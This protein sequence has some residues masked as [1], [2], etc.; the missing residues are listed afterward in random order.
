[1]RVLL[2]KDFTIELKSVDKVIN[3]NDVM[4][5]RL[6]VEVEENFLLPGERL[7]VV[8]SK[9]KDNP[10]DDITKEIQLGTDNK[11]YSVAIPQGV[12]MQEGTW[13]F[14]LSARKYYSEEKYFTRMATA[15]YEFTVEGGLWID[16]A[17]SEVVNNGTAQSLYE[18]AT[19]KLAIEQ[20]NAKDIVAL[21]EKN[22][23]QDAVHEAFKQETTEEIGATQGYI[24]RV[25]AQ[26][27]QDIE[28]IRVVANRAES[29]AYNAE[30]GLSVVSTQVN[31][32]NDRINSLKLYEIVSSLPASGDTNKLYLVPSSKQ[33]EDNVLE[34]WLWVNSS[35]EMVG[36]MKA[37]TVENLKNGAGVGAV[38]QLADGVEN[39]FDFTGKNPNAETIDE[40]LSGTQP[41]GAIGDFANAFG[42]KSSAQGKRS[43]TEGTTTIAKGKYSHAEGDNS[44]ALGDDSHAEGYQT[45]AGK[46]SDGAYIAQHAEGMRTQ[47]LGWAAHSEGS[48]TI[49]KGNNS[50]A[51]GSHT[52][53]GW[54]DQ[55]VIG[56]YNDNK[57]GNLFEVGNGTSEDNRSNA[58]E[59][60]DN[61]TAYAGGKRLLREGDASGGGTKLYKHTTIVAISPDTQNYQDITLS[62]QSTVPY[63]S[64]DIIN[65]MIE[66]NEIYRF[67]GASFEDKYG[68]THVVQFACVFSNILCFWCKCTNDMEDAPFFIEYV[69][70]DEVEEL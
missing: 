53:A 16:D 10:T 49:A 34:E 48:D 44:V 63:A 14:I 54:N 21:Q 20:E 50:H 36:T 60:K 52:I 6:E 37:S 30:T 59:V 56:R 5:S 24:A 33:E 23:A 4:V 3:V 26:A 41:Y 66:R 70:N 32:L 38:Q 42:G 15:P 31:S 45:V 55:T 39:G 51:G 25:E 28:A 17:T 19:E 67:T 43:H 40:T 64:T 47:A 12:V 61:G 69:A 8:F 29:M 2:K 7:W 18:M 13:Y 46:K 1:M 65:K 11:T 35:W 9:T 58:F 68:D 62:F 27:T 57:Y 22:A